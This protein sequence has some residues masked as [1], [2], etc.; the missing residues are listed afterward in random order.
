MPTLDELLADDEEEAPKPTLDELLADDE[1]KP[2]PGSRAKTPTAADLK[3]FEEWNK[4]PAEL[5][6][7]RRAAQGAND[8]LA[9]AGQL[10][11]HVVPDAVLNAGRKVTDPLVNAVM[12]GPAVDSSNT[13]TADFDQ[14][15]R[16][17]EAGYQA[18]RKAAGQEGMDW[19]RV[20]GM[21]ANPMTW[22]GG[23]G[24]KTAMQAGWQ[25]MKAG[26]LQAL[27]QPVTDEGTFGINKGIQTGVGAAVG[28]VLGAAL[29]G[30]GRGISAVASKF[31][32]KGPEAATEATEEVLKEVGADPAKVNPSI[33]SAIK[34][35][36]GDALK[37][38]VKPDPKVMLNRAEAASLPVPIQLTR[39]QATRDPM[40]F[41]WEV[42]NS[43]LRGA[44]EP[45]TDLISRQNR[46]LIENLNVLGAKD[47]PST[48]DAS[49][50][51]I[52]H[53]EDVDAAAKSKVDAAYALVR[54]A[55]GR[56]ARVSNEAFA[57][58]SKDLLT[59][60]R[61][62]MAE[63]A[64]LADYLPEPIVKQYNAIINGKLPLTVDTVQ[65]LDRNWGGIQRGAGDDTAKKAI[66]ALRQSLNEAPVSDQLGEQSM[67]AYKAAR[68]LAKQRFAA[69]E[70][71]PAYKAV[72][73]GVEPD[74]FFQKYIQGANV[75][76]LAGLKKLAGPENTAM[77]Q[78][79]LIGNLKKVALNR[80]SDDNGVFSQA[81][82]NKVL[83]DPVQ[84]PR[85]KELFAD[86]P[87]T[88][89]QLYRL[90]RVAENVVSFP[91]GHSVNTSNTA[92]TTANIVRDV[93]KS[94][95]GASLTNLIPGAR[96]MREVS[97][98]RAA[99]KAVE[100]AMKPGV[101]ALPLKPASP[102]AKV[103]RISELLSVAGAGTAAREST[104]KREKRAN[105]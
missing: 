50:K 5:P 104:Q 27:M 47:A 22:A 53:I 59:G 102:P 77:L 71:N 45:L 35:E 6:W 10:V 94:E 85:L 18:E 98:Q 63:L 14:G 80:A 92:P 39:G 76:E 79:T 82:Y 17:R 55:E 62:E 65:F 13:S 91:K 44:G 96:V 23:G 93:V 3:A 56:T 34:E 81:A 69:Q 86:R 54:D 78:Q 57:T 29:Y 26:A 43:K 64:S 58:H 16:N 73:D 9:G 12:G 74:K 37:A 51:I 100:Q 46:E 21:V 67:Q 30:V 4:A 61:P 103:G 24:A 105:D 60:G 31:K 83:Q 70:A 15:V 8:P 87:Q 68:E 48:F 75:N 40:Q 36:V 88:L 49:T 95:A 2:T 99:S 7:W 25:G 52:K 19:W 101:T 84:G 28:G 41:S 33:Y 38:D 72:V 66:G 32:D 20:G 90:G 1:P 89:E 42:N 97:A 11:Q